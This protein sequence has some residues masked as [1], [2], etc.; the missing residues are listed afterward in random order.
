MAKNRSSFLGNVL[1]GAGYRARKLLSANGGGIGLSRYKAWKLK[2]LPYNSPHTFDLKGTTIHFNNGPEL[3][4]SLKEIFI[5]EVYR[6]PFR[7]NAPYIID[8][9][10]NIGLAILYLTRQ[11]PDARI[12]AFEPD[13]ANFSFLQKNIAANNLVNVEL[14]KEAVWKEDTTLQFASE[15]TLGSR[16]NQDGAGQDTISVKAT[17]LKNLLDRPVD[18]LKM[19][20]EGAEYEVLKDCADSLR[21]VDNLF[22]EFHGYFNKMHELTEILQIVQ[23]NH[24][25]YYIREAATVYPTPFY[26]KNAPKYQYDI[27]LNIFCFKNHA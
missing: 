9:G 15:G 18:F 14:H 7:N 20:I 17:R 26:R 3:L 11:Y 12:I 24:F 1:H 6:I 16:I 19:D 23:D 21:H 25:S 4:H 8:C 2:H 10:S 5:D 22:I 13:S 27:Q